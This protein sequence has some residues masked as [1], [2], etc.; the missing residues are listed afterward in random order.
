VIHCQTCQCR[1]AVETSLSRMRADDSQSSHL[2]APA[3]PQS[4]RNAGTCTHPETC[5]THSTLHQN[6]DALA[7]LDGKAPRRQ[8][9]VSFL[10]YHASETFAYHAL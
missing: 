1:N 2:A 6:D 10:G 5:D 8:T 3:A 9:E 7:A 4:V